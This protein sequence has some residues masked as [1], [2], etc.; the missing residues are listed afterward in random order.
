MDYKQLAPFSPDFLWGASTSAYQVEGAWDADGKGR[1]VQDARINFPEGTTD[2]KVAADHYHR[3]EED[4]E[5]FAEL[6]LRAYRFSVAWTRIIPDGDGEVN[7]E[8]VAFYH[9]LLD[10]LLARGIEPVLT[11]YHFDLPQALQ[12]KGGWSNRATVDAFARFAKVLFTEYAGK[13][14]YWLT[15]NEQNMMILH[16]AAIGTAGDSGDPQRELYQQNHHMML[17]QA[18]AMQLCH[19]LVPNGKIGPAPN[20]SVVYPASAKPED[21]LAAADYNAIRNWLYLDMACRGSYNPTAWAWMTEKGIAPEI[22]DGDLEILASGRP[23]FLALNYYSTAT[24]A[25]PLG[26]GSDVGA[27]GGDQQLAVGEEGV[28][29]SVRNEHLPVNEFGWEIDPV[30][31]RSTLREVYDR[32][33]L[34]LMVTENGLGAFDTLE[35]DGTVHDRYRIDYLDAHIEQMRIAVTDGVEML[36]YCPWSAIDLISTHQGVRKRYGFIYVDR[37]EFDLKELKRYRKDSF[38]WYQQ[39]I[40]ANGSATRD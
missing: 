35:A 13:V 30:G 37:D 18:E 2:Y 39:L 17:A 32:Y 22:A 12:E 5:L 7:P 34:P 4:V 16:G 23:D 8:G 11:M 10:A 19:E 27:M 21:V 36:G 9:R 20:I 15:I 24:V 6:G 33:R 14:R 40:K 25:A 29:R 1:S 31:F 38:F 28:Y 3:F 26:T